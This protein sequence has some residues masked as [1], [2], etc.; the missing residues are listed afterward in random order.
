MGSF[1]SSQEQASSS[2][3]APLAGPVSRRIE[4]LPHQ[5]RDLRAVELEARH[6][7]LVRQRAVAVFQ[8][9]PGEAERLIV[10]AIFFATVSGE[11][12]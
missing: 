9:E 3:A 11:P 2:S 8:V 10:A 1:A 6:L 7:R 4:Q 12:T 5:R